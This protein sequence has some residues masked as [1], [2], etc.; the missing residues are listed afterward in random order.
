[1]PAIHWA[2]SGHRRLSEENPFGM[3]GEVD[4]ESKTES[5]D[6]PLSAGSSMGEQ[7]QVDQTE[8]ADGLE[9]ILQKSATGEQSQETMMK[10]SSRIRRL[11]LGVCSKRR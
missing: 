3:D 8:W 4:I 2:H 7:S 6:V 11:N 5:R 1:M 9:G 10:P